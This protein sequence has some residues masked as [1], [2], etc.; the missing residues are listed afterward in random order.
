MV[1][2]DVMLADQT[3]IKEYF[4]TGRHNNVNVF[5]LVQSLHKIAK[6]CIRENANMF[7]LFRQDDN[8]LKYFHGTHITGDMDFKEFSQFCYTAWSKPHG[9]VVINLWDDSSYGRYWANYTDVYIPKNQKLII[10]H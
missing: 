6:H 7:I 10:S 4:C 2:D 8:T 9:F 3:K 1:F 5:Y